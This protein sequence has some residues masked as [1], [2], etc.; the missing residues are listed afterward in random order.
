MNSLIEKYNNW[1]KNPQNGEDLF[2]YGFILFIFRGI[3]GTTMFP[4]IGIIFKICF[5]IA[6]LL[7]TVKII[8]FDKYTLKMLI[9]VISMFACSVA[10]FL[11]S[12]Y[13]CTFFMDFANS[14]SKGC[15]L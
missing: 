6:I 9:A 5:G 13:F 11:S 8:L 7:L 2:F 14:S 15:T 4:Y 1:T 10:V 12:G 3:M